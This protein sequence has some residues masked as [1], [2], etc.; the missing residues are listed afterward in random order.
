MSELQLRQDVLDE[1]EFEPSVNAA[2]IGVVVDKEVVTLSGHVASYA[3]KMA[4]VAAARRIKGVRGIA[5]EIEVRYSSDKKTSDDEIAKRTIEILGW[6]TVV[7]SGS[8]QVMV[9]DGWVTLTGNVDWYYQKKAAEKD[10][11]KLSGVRG[12]IINNI[13][14]K[15]RVKAEDIKRKIEDALKR[16]AKVEAKAIRVTVRDNDKVLLEGKV[17]NW[18]ERYAVENAAWSAPGVRSVEDRLAIG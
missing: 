18:D 8:I 13:D 2:H 14:I 6:D 9:R 17:D 5:D 15:P 11:R 7:P 1:L 10:V 4:A 3:E 16:H 12:V